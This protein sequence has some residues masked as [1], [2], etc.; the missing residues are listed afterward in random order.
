LVKFLEI[1][2]KNLKE[3]HVNG[4]GSLNLII[5]KYCPN[6]KSLYT[7]FPKNEMETLKI[8]FNNCQQLESIKILCGKGYLTEK[9]IFR[10]VAKHSPK[11]FHELK[12]INF[13]IF[14]SDFETF[15]INWKDHVPQKSIE[16]NL[17]VQRKGIEILEKI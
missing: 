15:F 6:L 4:Y 8:I 1:N 3:F 9:E 11:S 17:K 5:T 16:C 13:V 7:L 14:E 12:L 10:I 2:G